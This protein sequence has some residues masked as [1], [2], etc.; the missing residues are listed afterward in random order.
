MQSYRDDGLPAGPS[1]SSSSYRNILPSKRDDPLGKYRSKYEESMNP[2]EAFRGRVRLFTLFAM[3]VS[4]F[5]QAH[6]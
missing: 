6:D 2:F 3:S 1:S 4:F 5:L